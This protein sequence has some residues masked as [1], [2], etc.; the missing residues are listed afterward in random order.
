MMFTN[1]DKAQ[2]ERFLIFSKV[3]EELERKYVTSVKSFKN[4]ETRFISL[5]SKYKHLS[6]SEYR[7]AVSFW[8]SREIRQ[9]NVTQPSRVEF[10][11]MH[12]PSFEP[13]FDEHID[14]NK[15]VSQVRSTL[16]QKQRESFDKYL[17]GFTNTELAD[18]HNISQQA[19]RQ[20]LR[21]ILK[22]IHKKGFSLT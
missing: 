3:V 22:K 7:T 21:A 5:D 9:I 19:Q 15:K 13:E 14:F 10:S 12:E 2:T 20:V 4:Y 1:F 18:R 16:T 11:E 17:L 6:K 8:L